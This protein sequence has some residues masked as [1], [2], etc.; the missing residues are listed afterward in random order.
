MSAF[1]WGGG[2]HSS[3][4]PVNWCQNVTAYLSNTS[5]GLNFRQISGF[6]V[7]RPACVTELVLLSDLCFLPVE[8][9]FICNV[10]GQACV[11]VCVLLDFFRGTVRLVT[12]WVCAT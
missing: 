6:W 8:P 4:N 1:F 5:T 9:R 3:I 7:S 12:A 11:C 2:G 10:E